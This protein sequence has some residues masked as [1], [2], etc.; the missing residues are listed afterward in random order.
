M[1]STTTKSSNRYLPLIGA[2]FVSGV[3]LFSVAGMP[4]PISAQTPEQ[5]QVQE[6]QQQANSQ[7]Q[8][9]TRIVEAGG[10][11]AVA[12]VTWFIPQNVTIRVGETVMW[13]NPTPVPEPHTI[14]FI[15]EPGYVANLDSAYLIPN[16]TELK[17]AVPGEINTEPV[18]MPGQNG[19]TTDNIIVAANN[20]ARSPVVID[21]QNNVIYLQPNANYTMSGDELFV[22]SGALWPE[23]LIAPGAPPVTSFSVT[24]ENAGTYDYLC[25]L[26]P[27]MTGQVIVQ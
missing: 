14:T 8:N 12:P 17:P 26:H 5:G 10:G 21:A 9:G 27:W 7:A 1:T 6:Q 3:L 22:N 25:I 23:G 15:R 24:F 11:D 2:V 16:G 18:I 4:S 20:R 19:T 13:T